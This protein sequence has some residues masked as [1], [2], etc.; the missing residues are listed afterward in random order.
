MQVNMRVTYDRDDVCEAMK[1]TYTDKFGSP[2]DGFE[3]FVR[4]P[5]GDAIIVETV[6]KEEPDVRDIF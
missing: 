5:Y 4:W 3:L 1:K 6:K 2:P